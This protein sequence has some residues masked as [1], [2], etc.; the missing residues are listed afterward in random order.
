MVTNVESSHSYP[1]IRAFYTEVHRVLAPGGYFLYTDLMPAPFV[2]EYLG[3]L[4]DLGFDLE[5]D[6]DITR[7]VLRS[8]DEMRACTWARLAPAT[9]ASS[10]TSPERRFR[11]VR[12]H[13]G[14][15]I[16][17]QTSQTE[18]T[19]RTF[20]ACR[21]MNPNE[22]MDID[23]TTGTDSV[24]RRLA[25]LS[26]EKRRAFQKLLNDAKPGLVGIPLRPAAGETPLSFAQQRLW[27]L[28]QLA[29]GDPRLQHPCGGAAAG[30]LERGG[31]GAQPERDGAAA[32]GAAD[33]V[34]G[35]GRAA[36][37]GG[38]GRR[39]SS[40][41]R[42][43]TCGAWRRR[44]GRRRRGGWRR[45][46]AAAVRPGARPAAAGA[47]C[48]SWG[49]RARVWSDAAPHRHRRLVDGRAVRGS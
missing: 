3:A 6:R 11:R 12:Q 15:Q 22:A 46:G 24:A 32:R 39:W 38:G 43:W 26:P 10:T 25:T 41:R 13:A 14:R 2:H 28:D 23:T 40:R 21:S 33:D 36:G 47:G 9:S 18:E 48:C 35:S 17:L 7:N 8:C 19:R 31:A 49:G 37:A 45:R 34:R 27:F 16:D 20:L 5:R 1:D 4:I 29:P 30:P 44:R 42:W